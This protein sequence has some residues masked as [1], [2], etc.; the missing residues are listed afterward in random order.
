MNSPNDVVMHL[1]ELSR[2]LDAAVKELARLDEA[3]VRA[4]ARHEVEFAR[5]F[6][7]SDGSMDVRRYTAVE[8]CADRKLDAEI[9]EQRVRSQRE[10]I[11]TIQTR[12]DVGRTVS[13]TVR[14]E[15]SLA[16]VS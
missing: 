9:S 11:R 15:I 4:R 14:S 10:L 6:L 7:T 3:A 13:A 1:T 8:A 16:G 2:Q 5:A 12:I